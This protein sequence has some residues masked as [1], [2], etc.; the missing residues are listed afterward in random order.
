MKGH[1]WF[2]EY[3][4]IYIRTSLRRSR[5]P[6]EE[7]S[8]TAHLLACL[9]AYTKRRRKETSHVDSEGDEGCILLSAVI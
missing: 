7:I 6:G 9:P 1:C 5:I 2:R 8:L 3:P 4:T